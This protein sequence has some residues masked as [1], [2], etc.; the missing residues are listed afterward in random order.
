M[1]KECCDPIIHLSL[2]AD[3]GCSQFRDDTSVCSSA[4]SISLSFFRLRLLNTRYSELRSSTSLWYRPHFILC[5]CVCVVW[6]IALRKNQKLRSEGVLWYTSSAGQEKTFTPTVVNFQSILAS[7]DHCLL[8]HSSPKHLFQLQ[9]AEEAKGVGATYPK[10]IV[11]PS[12]REIL[13]WFS[14]LAT[15]VN[16]AIHFNYTLSAA[17][18]NIVTFAQYRETTDH[19]D[20]NTFVVVFPDE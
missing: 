2:Q 12:P 16:G 1:A 6:L 18:H 4:Y 20:P 8:S 11:K 5:V 13:V 19:A 10:K 14:L 7:P 9:Y 3:F 15:E 17:N